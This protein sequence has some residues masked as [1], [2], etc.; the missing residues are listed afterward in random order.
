MLPKGDSRPRCRISTSS[1][2]YDSATISS[3]QGGMKSFPITEN[4]V[5]V[6][7]KYNRAM[8]H[9]DLNVISMVLHAKFLREQRNGIQMLYCLFCLLGEFQEKLW[10]RM[11]IYKRVCNPGEYLNI[12]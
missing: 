2:R 4:K 8:V 12:C 5:S 1:K 6:K 10:K 7:Y 11:A 9:E 3:C